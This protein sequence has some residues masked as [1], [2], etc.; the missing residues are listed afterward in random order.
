M[1]LGRPGDPCLD[2]CFPVFR[3]RLKKSLQV[4]TGG[5]ADWPGTGSGSGMMV[6]LGSPF[7]FQG[8]GCTA[9][10]AVGREAVGT[11]WGIFM[12]VNI[13]CLLPAE[14]KI[15]K[16]TK[17]NK[18]GDSYKKDDEGS[19]TTKDPADMD[20]AISID[21][22]LFSIDFGLFSIDFGLFS[23]LVGAY[24]RLILALFD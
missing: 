10:Y 12:L 11:M 13:C 8:I 14:L 17:K 19:N 18:T 3:T 2:G 9:I 22:G 6:F 20:G 1:I 16:S 5:Q 21:F 4:V 23:R 15:R 24:L 7:F